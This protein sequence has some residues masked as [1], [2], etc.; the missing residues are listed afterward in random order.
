MGNIDEMIYGHMTQA[1]LYAGISNAHDRINELTAEN[2]KLREQ[3][4]EALDMLVNVHDLCNL[5][6]EWAGKVA[7]VLAKNGIVSN[8]TP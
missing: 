6:E 1:E 8:D 2:A 3:L 4:A 7:M 5:D